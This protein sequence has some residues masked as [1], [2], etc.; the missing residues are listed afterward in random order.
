MT[1][2]QIP[3]LEEVF[4]YINTRKQD[5]Q[6]YWKVLDHNSYNMVEDLYF[7]GNYYTVLT[8]LMKFWK[9]EK[10]SDFISEELLFLYQYGTN[11]KWSTQDQETE[12]EPE[13]PTKELAIKRV[14]EEEIR[15]HNIELVECDLK[16]L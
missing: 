6:T 8:K 7:Q 3:T 1:S 11:Y 2:V 12:T 4:E 13:F 14:L 10:N 9:E 5:V 16:I 15:R